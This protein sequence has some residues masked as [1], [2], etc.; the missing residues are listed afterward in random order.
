MSETYRQ[1]EMGEFILDRR[2]VVKLLTPRREDKVREWILAE[3]KI[4]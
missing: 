3:V 1:G 2:S 4:A